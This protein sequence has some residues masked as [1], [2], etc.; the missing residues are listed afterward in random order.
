MINEELV[1]KPYKLTK[2]NKLMVT[3]FLTDFQVNKKF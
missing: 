3:V 2:I 1:K